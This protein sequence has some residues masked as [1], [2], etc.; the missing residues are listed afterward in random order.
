[1]KGTGAQAK[2]SHIIKRRGLAFDDFTT[3]PKLAAEMVGMVPFEPGDVALD[4]C[5]GGGAFLDAFPAS[6][7]A[8]WCEIKEG[9]DFLQRAEPADWIVSNPPYSC[10][11]DFF[12]HALRL[13]R[14]G[15]GFLLLAHHLTA[16]RIVQAQ[17]QGFE[18]AAL[19]VVKVQGWY[20]FAFFI[21]WRKGATGATVTGRV[22]RYRGSPGAWIKRHETRLDVGNLEASK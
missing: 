13:A 14:K 1:M 3:P 8:E 9:R 4:P 18:V 20:G 10:L 16:R 11:D 5:R 22:E 2:R 15:V 6:T 17:E 19:H 12:G 21:L 7:R